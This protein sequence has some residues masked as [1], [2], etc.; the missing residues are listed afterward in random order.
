MIPGETCKG[1]KY[2]ASSGDGNKR[3]RDLIRLDLVRISS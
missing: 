3:S 2:N 1:A